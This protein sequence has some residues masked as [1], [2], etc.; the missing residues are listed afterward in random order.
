MLSNPGCGFEIKSTHRKRPF[1]RGEIHTIVA[2]GRHMLVNPFPYIYWGMAAAGI[3]FHSDGSGRKVVDQTVCRHV[4]ATIGETAILT[5]W[6]N[7]SF[8]FT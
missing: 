1:R 6:L 2:S 4:T 5:A 7:V 8:A 3:S